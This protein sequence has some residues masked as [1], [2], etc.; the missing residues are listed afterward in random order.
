MSFYENLKF[1]SN[2]LIPAI[3]QDDEQAG[4]IGGKSYIDRKG[5][6]IEMCQL[7]PTFDTPDTNPSKVISAGVAG[8]CP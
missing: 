1:D 6:N 3:V 5:I 4:T 7:I 8:N 2:G